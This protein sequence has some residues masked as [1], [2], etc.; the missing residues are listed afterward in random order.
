MLDHG[1]IAVLTAATR[2][3]HQQGRATGHGGERVCLTM[4]WE[5][6]RSEVH[7]CR[8]YL[9]SGVAQLLPFSWFVADGRHRDQDSGSTHEKGCPR[10]RWSALVSGDD[11]LVLSFG[12]NVAILLLVIII[13]RTGEFLNAAVLFSTVW[14]TNLVCCVVLPYQGVAS[15]AH[16]AYRRRCRM[17]GVPCRVPRWVLSPLACA[18]RARDDLP[19]PRGSFAR[20]PDWPSGRQRS[21]R[22]PADRAAFEQRQHP[23]RPCRSAPDAAQRCRRRG[24]YS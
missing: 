23:R 22:G 21:S 14:G 10:I 2:V 12:S 20:G 16:D 7:Y 4:L 6:V 19:P 5:M 18:T 17:V 24:G 13:R 11:I 8:T 15:A 1:R 9:G 3:V